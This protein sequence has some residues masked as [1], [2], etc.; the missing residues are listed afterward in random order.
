[1]AG[2]SPENAGEG[3][4]ARCAYQK[5]Q[6]VSSNSGTSRRVAGTLRFGEDFSPEFLLRRVEEVAH[7]GVVLVHEMQ[8]KRVREVRNT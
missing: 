8:R 4:G 3:E 6:E 5:M 7:R 1:M 2:L